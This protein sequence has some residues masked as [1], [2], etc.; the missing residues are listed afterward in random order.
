[1]NSIDAKGN[2]FLQLNAPGNDGYGQEGSKG[3]NGTDGNSV[4]FSSY[5]DASVQECVNL[6][7]AGQELS[8]NPQY[9]SE[10]VEY[11]TND[12]II[13]KSGHVYMLN[14]DTDNNTVSYLRM[15]NIFSYGSAIDNVDCKLHVNNTANSEFYYKVPNENY[16]GEYNDNT[17]SPYIYHRDR[18]KGFYCGSWI[19]F[20]VNTTELSDCLYKYVLML[21]N[22]L[23]IENTTTTSKHQ[24][25]VDNRFLYGCLFD[26][27]TSSED[28]TLKEI[29]NYHSINENNEYGYNFTRALSQKIIDTCTAYVEVTDLISHKVYRRYA[30]QIV[31]DDTNIALEEET[32]STIE[33]NEE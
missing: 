19:V 33:S 23:K 12:V 28:P 18:Y 29:G 1:M 24:M 2:E 25:F 13:D 10:H 6:I 3:E 30:R 16:I 9:V 15:H 32:A 14:I 26:E 5:K 20:N 31:R 8:N 4:Y 11:K 21:P 17:G 22:G 7:L 27:P